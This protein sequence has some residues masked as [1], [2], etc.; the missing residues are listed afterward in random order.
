VYGSRTAKQQVPAVGVAE[1]LRGK[2]HPDVN[3]GTIKA[4]G[5]KAT[6]SDTINA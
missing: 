1:R 6:G 4:G 3:S 5:G 2:L